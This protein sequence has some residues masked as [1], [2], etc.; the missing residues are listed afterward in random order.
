MSL[1]ANETIK[2]EKLLRRNNKKFVIQ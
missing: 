1:K 2:D